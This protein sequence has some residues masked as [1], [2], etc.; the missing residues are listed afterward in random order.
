DGLAQILVPV[1]APGV[2]LRPAEGLDVTR[3]WCAVQLD[4]VPVAAHDL[5]GEPGPA[6]EAA[7]AQQAQLAA[8][9]ASAE[10]V[11]AMHADFALAVQYAKDRI[12]FGGRIGSFQAVKPLLADTSLWLEMAKGIVA[13]AA[14]A[15]GRGAPDGAAL[16]HAAK[17]FVSERSVELAHNCFQ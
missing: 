7:V 3:S 5:V 2:T 13:A 15:L 10:M 17:A 1:A 16:A 12:A 14:T 9:L 6:T 8:V 4:G 11:G